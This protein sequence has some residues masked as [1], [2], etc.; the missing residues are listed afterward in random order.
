MS[1]YETKKKIS[2]VLALLILLSLVV[3]GTYNLATA[4]NSKSPAAVRLNAPVVNSDSSVT[5]TLKA[6]QANDVQLNFQNQA[7][8]FTCCRRIPNDER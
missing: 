1:N 6:P 7:G 8:P 5:F 3:L 2:L 4:D